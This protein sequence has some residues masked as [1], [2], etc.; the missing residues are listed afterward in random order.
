MRTVSPARGG[1]FLG[2][3][4]R[5]EVEAGV[6]G[7][8]GA[9]LVAKH[10]AVDLAHVTRLQIAELE[11]TEGDADEPVHGEP[12]LAQHLL[13]LAVL[14]L[15]EADDQPGVGALEPL[16]GRLDRAVADAVDG[17]ALP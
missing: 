9:E 10:A 3:Q 8:L 14:A 4:R 1:R 16:E 7:E 11:G 12:E 5:V 15:P 6:P 2:A 13:D 17:D